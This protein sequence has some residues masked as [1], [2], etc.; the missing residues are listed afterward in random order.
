MI[1][2]LEN[3]RLPRV[4]HKPRLVVGDQYRVLFLKGPVPLPWL[5]QAGALPGRALHVGLALW[6]LVGV[7]K[8][9]TVRLA[10]AATRGFGMN[11]HAA[12]RAL[13]QLERSGL[14]TV[15][16]RSGSSPVVTLHEARPSW[17]GKT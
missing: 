2:D 1:I 13:R 14:I 12:Y 15:S 7:N 5:H 8:S 6:F 4:R 11:R 9:M 16:R 17:R 10:P 3:Y